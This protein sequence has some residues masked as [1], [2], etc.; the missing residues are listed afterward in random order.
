MSGSLSISSSSM[1]RVT[2]LSSGLDVDSLVSA[3]L[4]LEKSKLSK[5]GQNK[6]VLQWQQDSYRDVISS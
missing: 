5:L 2:G 3:A 6:Q 1:T 4:Q